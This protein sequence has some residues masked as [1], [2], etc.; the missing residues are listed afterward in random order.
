[1]VTTDFVYSKRVLS[2]ALT[3]IGF[4][5]AVAT[6]V[7]AQQGA[8][9]EEYR[10]ARMDIIDTAL[11]QAQLKF[12]EETADNVNFVGRDTAV[13]PEVNQK[14]PEIPID[15]NTFNF[16][17]KYARENAAG[18]SLKKH[19]LEIGAE[20]FYFRY[21]EPGVMKDVGT[22]RGIYSRYAFRPSPGDPLYTNILNLYEIEGRYSFG[23][24]DYE[25]SN[26]AALDDIDDWS[27]ELR[28]ILG[29]EY[30]DGP[31]TI[32]IYSGIGYRYL[33]DDTSGRISTVGN[34]GYYGYQ[35]E[36]NYYYLPAGFEFSNRINDTWSFALLGE[37]DFFVY[38]LQKSHLSDGNQFISTKND[39]IENPQHHGY[40]LRGALKIT[41]ESNIANFILEPFIR[42]WNIEDSDIV[43]AFVDGTAGNFVE[44]ENNTIEAGLKIG[45][46]F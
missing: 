39:D 15:E 9:P 46:Q 45:L 28:G 29:K 7:F 38:G 34:A 33:N 37:Y 40:G 36:S 35:R 10:L 5:V 14:L 23:G 3:L 19:L 13:P 4:F 42:Y 20:S 26:G 2:R 6:P 30:V 21:K 17:E 32:I 31:F 16:S 1:M 25:A 44:P 43:S 27:A 12:Y 41:R 8:S 24:V 18:G 22:M 11:A